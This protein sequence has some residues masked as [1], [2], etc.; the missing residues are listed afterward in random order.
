VQLSKASPGRP[1]RFEAAE[2][3]ELIFKAAFEVMRRNDYQEV[4]VAD[5]LAEAGMSTRSFYRHF[6][7]KDELL[8]AMYRRDAERAA[9][10]LNA[11]VQR[12]GSP[13]EALEAWI[14]EILSFGFDRARARRAAVLG[15]PGAMR[16]EGSR[17]EARH[18]V[19]LLT[20]PLLSILELGRDDGTF[21]QSNPTSDA[22]MITAFTLDAAGL[23]A[24][25]T[26]QS[27]TEAR[28]DVLAF[29]L[30]ALG[31]V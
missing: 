17:E 24:A 15:S 23:S 10:R 19:D 25:G 7:S 14:D 16:A 6:G 22:R 1:R 30:R 13:R 4:T 31:A 3:I 21:S 18:A 8:C 28:R 11:R 20:T 9:E 26:R 29:T 2:E 12:A 5:I 27:R